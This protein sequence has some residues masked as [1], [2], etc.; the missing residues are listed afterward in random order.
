[1][2]G[3]L[4]PAVFFWQITTVFL[5]LIARSRP[6]CYMQLH[7]SAIRAATFSPSI[8]ALTMPPA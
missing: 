6:A 4:M 3:R 5:R 1:M 2:N 7:S 8:A